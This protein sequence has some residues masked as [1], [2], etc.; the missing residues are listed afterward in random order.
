M[1]NKFSCHVKAGKL[2][3]IGISLDLFKDL[4]CD[5]VRGAPVFLSRKHPVDIHVF[6]AKKSSG[7]IHAQ[8][9]DH[10]DHH[11]ALSRIDTAIC[12]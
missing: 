4:E 11:N 7:Y 10:G 8:S 1:G 9:I 3:S 6:N 12:L 5:P 2:D